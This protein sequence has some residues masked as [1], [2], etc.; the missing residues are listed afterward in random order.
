MTI[1]PKPEV[2]EPVKNE[3]KLEVEEPEKNE[4]KSEELKQIDS[5]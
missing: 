3:S 4:S 5:N 2:E 1:L